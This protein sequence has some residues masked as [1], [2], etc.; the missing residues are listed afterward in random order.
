M[1]HPSWSRG[2]RQS[3]EGGSVKA[4]FLPLCWGK[5]LCG[6]SPF[7][8]APEGVG[9]IKKL[10]KLSRE[11]SLSTPF[12]TYHSTPTAK[13]PGEPSS[14]ILSVLTLAGSCL[15]C[16]VGKEATCGSVVTSWGPL[17]S[18]QERPVEALGH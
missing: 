14:S 1:D 8:Q 18:A 17:P 6:V 5:L 12:P 10:A 4:S 7:L 13:G 3:L 11:L 15:R 9:R 16:S 2:Q